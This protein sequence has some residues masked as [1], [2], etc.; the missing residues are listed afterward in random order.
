MIV[1]RKDSHGN[2][3]YGVRVYRDGKRVWLGTFNKEG[4]ADK[5]GT[6]KWAEAQALIKPTHTGP[7]CDDFTRS[8][9]DAGCPRVSGRRLKADTLFEYQTRLSSF[10]R[11]FK[12]KPLT[13]MSRED[14]FGWALSHRA[15][16]Q[17]VRALFSH[18]N[19]LEP[20][21]VVALGR[22]ASATEEVEEPKHGVLPV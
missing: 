8:W 21:A 4:R 10:L 22:P 3:R 13:E 6:A 18:A 16:V 5:P 9:L 19:D 12:G 7:T 11:D 17:F 15:Q 14:A 2:I 20:S 1:K